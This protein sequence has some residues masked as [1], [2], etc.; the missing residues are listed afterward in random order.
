MPSLRAIVVGLRQTHM[1]SSMLR[2]NLGTLLKLKAHRIMFTVN[3]MV[4]ISITDLG[5]WGS[6]GGQLSKQHSSTELLRGDMTILCEAADDLPI[7]MEFGNLH[8]T[9][10]LKAASD[11]LNGSSGIYCIKWLENDSISNIHLQM[12]LLFTTRKN[13]YNFNPIAGLPPS[14]TGENHTEETKAKIGAAHRG[15][16]NSEKTCAKMSAAKKGVARG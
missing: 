13:S 8:L 16:I 15:K 9:E 2:D 6:E 11:T 10:S 12:P 1:V 3:K 5:D 7:L 4:T 14:R